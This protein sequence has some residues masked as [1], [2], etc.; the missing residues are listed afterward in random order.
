M[1]RLQRFHRIN[2]KQPEWVWTSY[3]RSASVWTLNFINDLITVETN[4]SVGPSTFICHT[5]R[6][7][8]IEHIRT[9]SDNP[10]CTIHAFFNMMTP[11]NGQ[12]SG[13]FW[14]LEVCYNFEF[15]NKSQKFQVHNQTLE[16]ENVFGDSCWKCILHFPP[17]WAS[18]QLLTVT[19]AS[20]YY[21][22]LVWF[23]NRA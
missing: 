4:L 9:L 14:T 23:T 21:Y 6:W 7:N 15:S 19:S 2:S 13:K 16:H 3:E 22:G 20:L 8:H 5:R 17:F 11:N 12:L 18:I 1:H 10:A